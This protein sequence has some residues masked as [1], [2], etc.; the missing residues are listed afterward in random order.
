MANT[1]Y[2]QH[3]APSGGGQQDLPP[4][5]WTGKLTLFVVFPTAIGLLG[6]YT[7]HLQKRDDPNEELSFDT[8]FAYPFILALAL[9]IVVGWKTSGFQSTK[10]K[11]FVAW[12]KVKKRQ[13]IVHKHVVKGQHPDDAPDD[14]EEEDEDE[15]DDEPV[16]KDDTAKKDD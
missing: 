10:P 3:T 11:P 2:A 14:E 15:G 4:L 9:V 6:L 5:T 13:K 16:E 12:P 8:D 1:N 7:G